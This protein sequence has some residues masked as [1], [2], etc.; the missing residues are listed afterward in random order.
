MGIR[1]L[2]EAICKEKG[3]TQT[4]V[5]KSGEPKMK[6]LNLFEKIN[7]LKEKNIIDE[8]QKQVLPQIRDMGNHTKNT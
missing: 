4:Q 3:I 1:M 2:V 6:N 7:T 5:M 8:A